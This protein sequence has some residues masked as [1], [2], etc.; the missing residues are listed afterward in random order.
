MISRTN[1]LVCKAYHRRRAIRNWNPD[2]IKTIPQINAANHFSVVA[3]NG[4][5]YPYKFDSCGLRKITG[6]NKKKNPFINHDGY[7]SYSLYG[8]NIY[9][10][11]NKDDVKNL[12][13]IGES[14]FNALLNDGRIAAIK[15]INRYIVSSGLEIDALPCFE[16][17]YS[18]VALFKN[19]KIVK[20][21]MGIRTTS[22]LTINDAWELATLT[23]R[24]PVSVRRVSDGYRLFFNPPVSN[25][26]FYG[27]IPC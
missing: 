4:I 20:W 26:A 19:G 2:S 15:L 18:P 24:A 3:E 8:Y 17:S 13:N 9:N 6:Q 1:L 16:Q 5:G 12:F 27:A 21:E 23:L 14:E 22:K 10:S 11:F 7:S 25:P